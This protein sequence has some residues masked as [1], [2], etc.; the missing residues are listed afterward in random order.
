MNRNTLAIACAAAVLALPAAAQVPGT[1]RALG[2]GNA[3]IGVARGTEALFFNPANLALPN[4]PHWSANFPTISLGAG[5]RGVELGDLWALREFDDMTQEE[6]DALLADIPAEGTGLDLDVRAP[7][8]ALSVRRFAFAVSYG[9]IASHTVN[10]S[11][12][13]LVLNGYQLGE[14]YTINDTEGFRASFF[15]IAAAYGH[16]IGPVALGVTGHAY[17]PTALS[18]SGLVDVDTTFA[19]PV[20]TDIRVT[21]S[22]VRTEGGSGFGLDVGA[23]MELIPGLTVGA[24]ISDLVN[25]LAW[26]DGLRT[27]TVVLD[28]NDYENG[29][30]EFI[31]RR[32]QESGAEYDDA[33]ALPGTRALAQRVLDD[34]DAGLPATLRLGAAYALR[35]GT[36]LGAGYQK[37]LDED[38][39]FGQMWNQQLSLGV[40]QR[41]P[42]IT[43]RAGL[44]TDLED[45]N[46]LSGGLSLGPL[47]LGIARVNSGAGVTER[48]GWI[49][50]VGLGGRS[51][52]T[53]P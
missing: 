46:M 43:L 14:T 52:S 49:A 35:T 47:Q 34:R 27:R 51:D 45:G 39:P 6:R 24:S 10:R 31:L 16:R 40:Q 36:T 9:T 42:V 44:A 15:D 19:G 8:A 25:T 22:G 26:D 20:P 41:L 12:V 21:Y 33:T 2:M 50:T 30:P 32:Y 23:A 28:Q 37:E 3:Y 5:A 7:F 4:S 1:P 13:D 18:R 38:S 48:S 29:D 17:F 11:I 53:M